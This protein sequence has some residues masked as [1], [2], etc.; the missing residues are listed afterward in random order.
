MSDVARVVSRVEGPAPPVSRET[1]ASYTQRFM[2]GDALTQL[3]VAA[4]AAAASGLRLYGTVAA[5]GLLDHYGVL[6]LPPGLEVLGKPVI[7][8]MAAGLYVAEFHS[9]KVLR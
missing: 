9:G 3:G 8:W 1:R 4:G 5:L 2:G 7:I 6:H